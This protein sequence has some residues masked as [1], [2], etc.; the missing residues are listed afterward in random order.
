MALWHFLNVP[1]MRTFFEQSRARWMEQV[2]SVPKRNTEFKDALE[3]L[4]E[5]FNI[6]N[7]KKESQP[8]HGE[9]WVFVPPE[10]MRAKLEASRKSFDE[11]ISIVAWPLQCRQTP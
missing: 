9:K 6:D 11:R 2:K 3:S 4:I 1:E 10:R 8:D 7:Y 5:S